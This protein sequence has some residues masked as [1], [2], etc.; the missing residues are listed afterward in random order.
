M[1]CLDFLSFIPL[2]KDLPGL[3]GGK[4]IL[5]NLLTAVQNIIDFSKCQRSDKM[6]N[7]KIVVILLSAFLNIILFFV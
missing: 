7:H 3:L 2:K 1:S 6:K 5:E 4:Q